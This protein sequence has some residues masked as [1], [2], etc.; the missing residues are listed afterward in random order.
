MKLQK[1]LYDTGVYEEYFKSHDDNNNFYCRPLNDYAVQ[2]LNSQPVS[3]IST[4]SDDIWVPAP[5]FS[6]SQYD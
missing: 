2:G 6:N 4:R 3:H 5:R 1:D